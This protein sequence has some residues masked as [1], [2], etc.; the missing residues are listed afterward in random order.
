MQI[1][2]VREAI[3]EAA[4]AVELPAGIPKLTCS[5]YV[6]DAAIAPHFFIAGYEQDFDKVM[7][8][9]LDEVVFT[10]QILVGRTD[11]QASQRLLDSMLSGSGPASLKQAIEVARGGPGEYAL[12]GLAHDLH[13]MRVQGYRWYEHAGS[14]YVGAE[15]MIKVIGEGG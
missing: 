3:A 8:R 2:A 11:D 15:L 1:S 4:R 5:G 9:G 12:G 13:V 7:H 14:T 6:P 10:T